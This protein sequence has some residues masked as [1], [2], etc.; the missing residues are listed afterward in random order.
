MFWKQMSRIILVY[1]LKWIIFIVKQFEKEEN[2][3]DN[4]N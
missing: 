3:E 1:I 2:K 4:F